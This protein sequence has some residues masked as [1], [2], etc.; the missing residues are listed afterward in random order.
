MVICCRCLL[1]H[2]H[3]IIEGPSVRGGGAASD[4]IVLDLPGHPPLI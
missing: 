1:I 4:L 3:F 2:V